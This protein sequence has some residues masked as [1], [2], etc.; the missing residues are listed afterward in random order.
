[1]LYSH[2]K[3]INKTP[4][5]AVLITGNYK[6]FAA[7]LKIFFIIHHLLHDPASVLEPPLD[8]SQKTINH[9]GV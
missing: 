9:A 2:Y 5:S 8:R 7:I 6:I 4:P 3:L 1:M